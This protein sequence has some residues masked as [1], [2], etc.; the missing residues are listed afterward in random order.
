MPVYEYKCG[1]GHVRE[2]EAPRTWSQEFAGQQC[3]KAL[4][5]GSACRGRL[6]RVYTLSFAPVDQAT[7]NPSVGKV[8]SDKRQFQDECKRLSEQQTAKTGIPHKYEMLDG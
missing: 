8:I 1:E 5:D 2:F 3:C 6:K 4:D 7:F